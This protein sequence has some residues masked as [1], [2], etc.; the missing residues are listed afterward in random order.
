MSQ[1]IE[2]ANNRKATEVRIYCNNQSLFEQVTGQQ[3]DHNPARATIDFCTHSW[4]GPGKPFT[5][6]DLADKELEGWD[7]RILNSLAS[8]TLTHEL[9]HVPVIGTQT[10]TINGQPIY[11]A[12]ALDLHGIVEDVNGYYRSTDQQM[13]SQKLQN[14]VM[15]AITNSDSYAYA[16]GLYILRTKQWRSDWDAA[17]SKIVLHKDA[18]LPLGRD[19]DQ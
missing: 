4:T 8:H 5:Y 9:T 3:S 17:N 10:F 12:K 14:N 18:S 16:L 2:N 7:V 19:W 15:Y 6:R 1:L 13:L 11:F